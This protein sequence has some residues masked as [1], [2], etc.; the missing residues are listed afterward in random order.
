MKVRILRTN[1]TVT[2]QDIPFS[3][4]NYP[5]AQMRH[6][7]SN[8]L[9]IIGSQLRREDPTI[10][11]VR[12]GPYHWVGYATAEHMEAVAKLEREGRRDW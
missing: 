2:S 10:A 8:A 3:W 1:G 7:D 6:H 11:S 4:S 5:D 12:L 9:C